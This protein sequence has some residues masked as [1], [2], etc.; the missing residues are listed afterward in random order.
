MNRA[1]F[2]EQLEK[3]LSDISED[4]RKE[5]LEY[6]ESY[7]DEAGPEKEA[8]VIQ[9]L[10][11]PGKVA[12]IIKADL[13]EHGEEYGEYTERGYYDER[14]EDPAQMPGRRREEHTGET[15]QGRSTSR[16]DR[17]E[18]GYHP[19]PKRGAGAIALIII[20]LIFL[21]PFLTGTVGGVL[22]VLAVII[23]LPFILIF[24]VGA[25]VI[26]L[27]IGGLVT[28]FA[29][30]GVCA[31]SPAMGVL[32]MGVG[33]ILTAVSLIGLVFV[34]W[35][36]GRLL[37]KALRGFTDFCHRILSREKRGGADV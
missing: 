8:S 7:F 1:Q 9:E 10:G 33:C 3:L 36:A 31:A 35:F 5:A 23:L 30:I 19:R 22:G 32:S 26:A 16:S 20:L 11:S 14:T 28:V 13:R 2:M 24:G 34:V 12:A 37:P 6:Y 21:A 17:A 15:E 18:R 25:V 27:F 29:G 4:E